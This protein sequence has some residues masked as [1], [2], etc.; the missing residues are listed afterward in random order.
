M[1]A[2]TVGFKV[3]EADLHRKSPK[4]FAGCMFASIV[5]TTVMLIYPLPEPENTIGKA[6]IDPVIIH[7]ENIPETRHKVNTPAPRLAIP[8]EIDD[9]MMPDDVTIESTALDLNAAVPPPLPIVDIPD[10]EANAEEEEDE[11]F[12][13]FAVEEEPERLNTVVPEYPQL[14]K[15]SN[16]QGTVYIKVLVNQTGIVDSIEVVKGPAVFH[17]SSINAAKDIIFKPAKINDMAVPCWVI[18]PFKFELKNMSQHR[19]R[20]GRNF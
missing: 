4:Y 11:I 5:L 14:A 20:R 8:L 12:E 17:K 2:S 6:K 1:K 10:I 7:L 19:R 16:V 15:D 18:I 13:I 9:E 3:P